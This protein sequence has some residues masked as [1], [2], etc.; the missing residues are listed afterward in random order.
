MQIANGL[1]NLCFHPLNAVVIRVVELLFVTISMKAA[2]RKLSSELFGV[3]AYRNV[4][5]ATHFA[6]ALR[7]TCY[8]MAM[9]FA[10]FKNCSVIRT[11]RPQ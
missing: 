2:Y 4:L 3:Q 8:R 11:S 5:A 6:I 7:L 1:G 10:Q 9:T